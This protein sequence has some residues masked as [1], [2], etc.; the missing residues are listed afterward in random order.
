MIENHRQRQHAAESMEKVELGS[1]KLLVIHAA[2]S[3]VLC[4]S[5]CL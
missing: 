4:G 5:H 1:L 3:S 2:S